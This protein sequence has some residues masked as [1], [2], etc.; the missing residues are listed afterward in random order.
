MKMEN[1]ECYNEITAYTVEIPIKDHNTIEVKEAQLKQ[2][3]KLMKYD[4][5][6]EVDNCGQ[7]TYPYTRFYF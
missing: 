4:L 1:S 5:F 3:E 2:I 6:K 7:H